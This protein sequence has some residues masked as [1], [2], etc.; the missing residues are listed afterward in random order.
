MDPAVQ[1]AVVAW[2]LSRHEQ[3]VHTVLVKVLAVWKEVYEIQY[4]LS[5]EWD[6]LQVFPEVWGL[7]LLVQGT[8]L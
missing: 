6:D 1:S 5:S 4:C 8:R 7:A 2:D 3:C